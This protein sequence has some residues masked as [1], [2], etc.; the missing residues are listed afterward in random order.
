MLRAGDSL[1]VKPKDVPGDPSELQ[2]GVPELLLH[3]YPVPVFTARDM[4]S[5]ANERFVTTSFMARA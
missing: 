3:L 4:L 5:T 2:L 1:S